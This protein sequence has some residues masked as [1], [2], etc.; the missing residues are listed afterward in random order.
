[1][2]AGEVDGALLDAAAEVIAEV[3]VDA[4]P[5]YRHVIAATASDAEGAAD[6]TRLRA[7]VVARVERLI[8]LRMPHVTAARRR[9]I[10][11]VQVETVHAVLFRAQELPPA[12]RRPMY[13]ELVRM[14]VAALEP[15]DRRP[16]PRRAGK[17]SR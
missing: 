4:H 14:L 12:G 16:P 2:A 10:A 5:A 11:T 3:G 7:V 15:L 17:G 6:D 8:A 1:M 9:V 13:E